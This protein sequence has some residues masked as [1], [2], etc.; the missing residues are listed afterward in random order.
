[1]AVFAILTSLLQVTAWRTALFGT[2]ADDLAL[3][4]PLLAALALT[5]L[6]PTVPA[7][8]RVDSWT[9]NAFLDW[10]EIPAEVKRRAATLTT[11][12]FTVTPKDVARLRAI[13]EYGDHLR[14]SRSDGLELSEYRFTRVVKLY[15]RIR[16]LA[17]EQ[18]YERYFSEASDELLALDRRMTAFVR[19]SDTW[20]TLASR[21]HDLE[22][23]PAYE[24]LMHDRR[25]TFAQS[26]REMFSAL[27]FFLARAV[28]RSEPHEKEIVGRLRDIGFETAEPMNRPQFPINSLTL[29]ALTVYAYL[30][31]T[32][33]FF[34]HLQSG[35]QLPGHGLVK[36]LEIAL[37]RV[38]TVGVVVWLI[39]RFRF[40]RR[41]PG[42]P[43]KYFAYVASG[44]ICSAV[45]ACVC[46]PFVLLGPSGLVIGLQN[47]LPVIFLSGLLC[48]ALALFCDDW[49]DDSV[50]PVWLRPVEAAGCAVVML[51]GTSFMYFADLLPP[52]LVSLAGWMGIV[53][54]VMPSTL[55]LM[56]GGFVPHMYRSARRVAAARRDEAACAVAAEQDQAPQPA[57]ARLLK[58]LRTEPPA[59]RAA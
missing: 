44:L 59:R 37:A 7:L 24:E 23:Q 20:L 41:E 53:W 33:I 43:R 49:P 21:L 52:S 14:D 34:S 35:P 45:A 40:F 48:T 30:A 26:C 42:E 56:I 2:N 31:S 9:L 32:T 55:A 29:L 51:L 38:I 46:L 58:D 50:P 1:V 17:G 13:D 11:D 27:A 47:S 16:E 8:Q 54:I 5:T 28:L 15:D 10:G 22:K 18:Q 25:E 12:K 4:A 57:A 36:A 3:P 19:R 39:Q 6:L